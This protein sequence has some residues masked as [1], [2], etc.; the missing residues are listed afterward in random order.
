[1]LSESYD[2][3]IVG[4]GV[5]GLYAALNLAGQKILIITK[6]K[7]EESDSFLAQGGICVLKSETDFTCFLEDTLRAGHYENNIEAVKTMISHSRETIEDLENYGVVFAKSKGEYLFT[8][9]GAHSTNRILYHKDITGKEITSK[10]ISKVKKQKN[11]E[12][13]ENAILLDLL[14]SD[15]CCTGAL[16]KY[17]DKL[18]Q[19]NA[20]NV[21]LATGG[22]GGMY[23][24]STNYS[25]LTGDSLVICYK[26]NIPLENINYVQ[27][28][29]T[30]LF[31]AEK[32]R[33]FLISES[34]RGEG[35]LLYNNHYER[36]AKETL[37]R[38]VLSNLILAEM[39]KEGSS[40]VWL[41][42]RPLGKDVILK[43]FPNIYETCKKMGY[44][45]LNNM[46]PVVPA[47]H[48]FMGGIK[49]D[50]N[51]KTSV[52]GLYAIG[53]V[54]CNGVHG[55]NRLASNSLLE[56]LVFAK[57]AAKN[58]LLENLPLKM[59]RN[60]TY[61]EKEMEEIRKKIEKIVKGELD[62]ELVR[63]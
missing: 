53:E 14:I 38:D 54:A 1:M 13:V 2:A 3:I 32:G 41:D 28:H 37:P 26:H 10:L 12:I 46:I 50:L 45:P 51:S 58:I 19:I 63:N 7:L 24:N 9:E 62:Y 34:V 30:S 23:K 52:E 61:N 20:R 33:R 59:T 16:I 21:L 31:Q 47:Q 43:H 39:A 55:R 8:K 25:H 18:Y 57:L 48:Y 44:D 29:P 11:V 6:A 27:I 17:Q 15:N 60:C 40:H 36:F 56:S 49:V 5:S 35:A 4:T 42:M 22:V